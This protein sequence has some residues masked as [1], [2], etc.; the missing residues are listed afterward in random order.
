[1]KCTICHKEVTL[2]P[3]A[4]ERA[5]RYGET[6]A[7]YTRLFPQ[8][9]V[10]TIAKRNADVRDLIALRDARKASRSD[11]LDRR[12]P[13]LDRDFDQFAMWS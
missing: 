6:P 4:A 13:V 10:C 11:H 5:K 3:S 8:H 1:M 2:V 7:Y 9:S 12:I